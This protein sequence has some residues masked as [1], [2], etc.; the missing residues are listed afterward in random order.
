MKPA[1]SHADCLPLRKAIL[2]TALLTFVFVV[3][4]FLIH[5]KMLQRLAL[6]WSCSS[7]TASKAAVRGMGGSQDFRGSAWLVP[8]LKPRSVCACAVPS[9]GGGNQLVLSMF[10]VA[11]IAC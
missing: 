1:S 10:H 9:Y 4:G 2:T 6:D 5:N 8:P 3:V 11:W 7:G